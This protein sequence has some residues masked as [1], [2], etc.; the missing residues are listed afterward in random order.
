MKMSNAC[1]NEGGSVAII[2][3]AVMMVVFC[4]LAGLTI[5]VSRAY[6]VKGEL[7]NVGDAVSLAGAGEFYPSVSYAV[8]NWSRAGE[9]ATRFVGKSRADGTD[10]AAGDVKY[11]WWNLSTNDWNGAPVTPGS[12]PILP[13]AGIRG[14]CSTSTGTVCTS[15]DNCPTSEVCLVKDVPAVM[16][17]IEKSAANNGAV[18]AVFAQAVGWKEFSVRSKAAVAVSGAP[19]SVAAY[20]VFPWAISKPM[21]DRFYALG[22]PSAEVQIFV[23]NQTPDIYKAGRWT[24]FD[25]NNN[26][27]LAS[28]GSQS[29]GSNP[30]RLSVNDSIGMVAGDTSNS[31]SNIP[32]GRDVLLPVVDDVTQNGYRDKPLLGF[33]TFRI[34]GSDAAQ[35]Y[36]RGQFITSVAPP[37]SRPG[38]PVYG[39]YTHPILVK[40]GS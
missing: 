37:N 33:I 13:P 14:N 29:M 23:Y 17:T 6:M 20:T 25:S 8:P 10:L 11:G 35:Q 26:V 4:V 38:G 28:L 1:R 18:P 36:I 31:F 39:V 30:S 34:T 22:L 7:Q 15:N 27:Q 3:T 12:T 40:K 16:T 32:V 9:T 5:D 19:S 2:M 21:A 24:S